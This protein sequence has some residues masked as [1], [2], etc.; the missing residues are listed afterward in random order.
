MRTVYRIREI[1]TGAEW[2]SLCGRES[3]GFIVLYSAVEFAG[4]GDYVYTNWTIDELGIG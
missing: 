2:W 3:P 1:A 4:N